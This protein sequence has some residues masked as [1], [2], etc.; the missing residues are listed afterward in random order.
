[1]ILAAAGYSGAGIA[2][3]RVRLWFG[4]HDDVQLLE[5]GLPLEFDR[6]RAS[7]LLDRDPA[8]LRI[9]LGLGDAVATVWTCDLSAEY[10]RINSEYTT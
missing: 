4:E 5:R 9:D 8:V 6:G 1:R 3:E 2:P 10:V 7:G